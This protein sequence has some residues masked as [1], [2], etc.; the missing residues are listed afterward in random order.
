MFFTFQS[1]FPKA[2]AGT[3]TM[4]KPFLVGAL[5]PPRAA[6]A[7]VPNEKDEPHWRKKR[8]PVKRLYAAAETLVF[9]CN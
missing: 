1:L 2:A 6:D 4:P 9:I 7:R 5:E 8:T 3:A